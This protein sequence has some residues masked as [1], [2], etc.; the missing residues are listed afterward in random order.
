MRLR[1]ARHWDY[2]LG[3][4]LILVACT[5]SVMSLGGFI[6]LI[7]PAIPVVF[8]GLSILRADSNGTCRAAWGMACIAV[9]H[10][11]IAMQFGGV[12]FRV[13]RWWMAVA[14]WG[15]IMLIF[16]TLYVLRVYHQHP[17]NKF[18]RDEIDAE[19]LCYLMGE[20][21]FNALI[22]KLTLEGQDVAD[23]PD[24]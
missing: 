17:F 24:L 22:H 13:D 6:C 3:G 5:Y 14:L 20:H 7:V 1:R 8:G 19:R 9:F 21:R 23:E 16:G 18:R 10:L 12:T 4:W 15:P 2:M 11:I